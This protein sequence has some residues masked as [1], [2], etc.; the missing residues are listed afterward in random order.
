[1]AEHTPGWDKPI[2]DLG[3][4]VRENVVQVGK[5]TEGATSVGFFSVVQKPGSD[6][7]AEQLAEAIKAAPWGFYQDEEI[8]RL[9]QGPSYIELGAW[10][11][12][13]GVALCLIGLGKI[14]GLWDVVIPAT[15]GIE[16]AE[17]EQMMGMGFIMIAPGKGTALIPT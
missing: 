6:L 3:T 10:I 1:M 13:Q 2:I 7:T 5:D 4:M 12:D 9:A 17:A 11:G 8:E 14:L 16:G 15:L